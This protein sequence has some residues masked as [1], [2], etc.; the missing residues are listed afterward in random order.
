L[1]DNSTF[2]LDEGYPAV[3][4]HEE[5]MALIMSADLHGLSY[6]ARLTVSDSGFFGPQGREVGGFEVQA[7]RYGRTI[8]FVEC[9]QYGDGEQHAVYLGQPGFD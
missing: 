6:L 3:A 5:M 4:H 1:E 2:F 9:P 7:P 8:G